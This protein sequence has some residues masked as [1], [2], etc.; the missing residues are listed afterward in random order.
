MAKLQRRLKKLPQRGARGKYKQALVKL[1]HIML[2]DV[3]CLVSG[4]FLC[5]IIQHVKR[6]EKSSPSNH[7]T[8]M[9][10]SSSW[11]EFRDDS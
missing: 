2:E 4:Y 5:L 1:W 8:S 9:Y 11:I 10:L 3:L 6:K 7:L